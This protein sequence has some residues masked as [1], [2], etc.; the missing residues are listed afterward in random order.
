MNARSEGVRVQPVGPAMTVIPIR[1]RDL[2]LP[3]LVAAVVVHLLVRLG[4][5]S[6][7]SF[8]LAAG[9][10][11]AVLGAAEAIGGT[12]LRSR[13]RDR[14]GARPVEPLIA[15]RAVLVA[16]ASAQAGAIMTGAW[17]G[18]LVYVAPRSADIA[19]AADDTAAAALGVVG[20]LVL[21]GGGLWLQH[22]CRTP[23]DPEDPKDGV[24]RGGGRS[25]D[26]AGR[27]PAKVRLA[28]QTWRLARR[29]DSR[30]RAGWVS[31]ASRCGRRP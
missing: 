1:P 26:P 5:G 9:L 31:G 2:V 28:R 3:A 8:P 19:A 16:R 4:Y 25:P 11:F 22:C 18:L 7:P 27:R 6:L 15:A 29:G 14:T 24:D 10:P 20:A 30:G 21:V 17:V 23:D 13:I 12:A